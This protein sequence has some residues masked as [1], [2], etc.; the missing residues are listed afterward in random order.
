MAGGIDQIYGLLLEGYNPGALVPGIVG[1]ICLL[2]ALFAFQ[3]LP[4][5][6]AVLAL[7]LLGIMLMV[8]EGFVPSFGALGMGGLAAF[9]FGSIIL[10]DSDIPG[11]GIA[12]SLIAG[13]ATVGG[14]A[15]LALIFM[16]MRARNR[17]IVSG[18]EAMV[19]HEATA[20]EDFDGDGAV[21]LDGERWRARSQHR[22]T[23]GERLRV[24]AIAGL[25]VSVEPTD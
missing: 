10:M 4:V 3:V 13:A 8:A 7:I 22:V 25:V 14:L 6:Y 17:P 21:L 20:L 24:T 16:L 12:R 11:F 9:I 19:S 5:N 2:L 23:K 1:S 15:M 18:I